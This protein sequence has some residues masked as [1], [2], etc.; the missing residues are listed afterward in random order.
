MARTLKALAPKLS[1]AERERAL[2]FAKRELACTGSTEEAGAVVA[3]LPADRDL[4]THGITEVLKY[5]NTPGE[6][7]DVLL[8]GLR[9]RWPDKDALE[10]K[11]TPT[12]I[13]V[14]LRWFNQNLHEGYL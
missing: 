3:S 13:P 7:A 2:D 8:T 9:E 11:T 10:G 6:P 1:G 12:E 14:W 4:F 5:P